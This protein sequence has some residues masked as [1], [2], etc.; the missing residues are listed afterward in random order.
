MNLEEQI[1]QEQMSQEV[2]QKSSF[3]PLLILGAIVGIGLVVYNRLLQVSKDKDVEADTEPPI[4]IKSGSFN[5]ETDVPLK[6]NSAG[7]PAYRR[8]GFGKIT[9]IRVVR[10]KERKKKSEADDFFETSDWNSANGV[11]VNINLQNCQQDQNGNCV[12]WN[13]GPTITISNSNNDFQVTTPIKLS[14][15]KLKNHPKRKAKREDEEVTQIFRFGSVEIREGISGDLIKLYPFENDDKNAWE[16]I[17]A[18]YNAL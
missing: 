11:Q 8:E 1:S 14:A 4:I 16:Y 2:A 7:L 9:G 18:F 15:S 5:I 10:Y 3:Q 12:S 13:P 17:I 6:P